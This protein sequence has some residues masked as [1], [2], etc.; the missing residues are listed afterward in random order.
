M[1]TDDQRA[2]Y[3][4]ESDKYYAAMLAE[5]EAK[6]P[7]P[8]AENVQPGKLTDEQKREIVDM[9]NGGM[10]FREIAAHFG[11]G[12]TTVARWYHRTKDKVAK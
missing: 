10:H 7:W 9:R 4:R 8:E 11:A 12:V 5:L 1:L 6:N 3:S 2:Q